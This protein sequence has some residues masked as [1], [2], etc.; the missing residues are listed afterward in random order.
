VLLQVTRGAALEIPYRIVVEKKIGETKGTLSFSITCPSQQEYSVKGPDG[1]E[2]ARGTTTGSDNKASVPNY[3]WPKAPPAPSSDTQGQITVD[4][5][6][7]QTSKSFPVSFES[8]NTKSVRDTATLKNDM[9]WPAWDRY[10]PAG[11]WLTTIPTTRPVAIGKVP[12]GVD[13]LTGDTT[14]QW[15][16]VVENTL[17]CFSGATVRTALLFKEAVGPTVTN[18]Q[19]GSQ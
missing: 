14:Y 10:F 16:W 11:G 7:S 1:A 19:W 15:T 6:A 4:C 13:T 5:L 12:S 3:S 2:I 18:Q 9:T 8:G 17:L